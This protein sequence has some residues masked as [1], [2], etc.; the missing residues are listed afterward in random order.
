MQKEI[1]NFF[2]EISE[3]YNSNTPLVVFRKPDEACITAYIQNNDELHYLNS[4][5]D[6]GFVFAPFNKNEKE[7][8]FPINECTLLTS[9]VSESADLKIKRND[10]NFNIISNEYSKENHIQLVNKGIDFIQNNNVK[11]VVLSRKETLEIDKIDVI[12]TLKKMLNSYKNAFVYLWYH[13]RVGLWMGASP[14]QLISVSHNKFK[15]MALAGTQLYENSTNVVWKEKEKQEQQF[16][17]DYILENIKLSIDTIKVSEAYTVKAG[18]LL[19]IRTD[20]SGKLKSSSSLSNLIDSLHPTPAV[21]G[22][23]KDKA[24]K[25]I[26]ENEEYNRSYY[27]GYLGE[28]NIDNCT[29]LFV[30][31]RCMQLNDNIV[32]IYI[33]GGITIDSIAENE[34]EETVSKAKVMKKIL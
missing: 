7:L 17:T 23:P 6:Q 4:F 5:E 9:E 2:N 13:P 14:E 20:I 22:L 28:L 26:L 32:S 34:W 30:N 3:F 27:T 12:D 31:L 29:S 10:S 33:G 11:K 18:N 15:T 16:V 24:I 25:F 21:C 8:L 19:H 1:I